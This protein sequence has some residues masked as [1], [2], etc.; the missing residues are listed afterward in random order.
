MRGRM[1]AHAGNRQTNV[2]KANFLLF[3]SF[4]Q[5]ATLARQGKMLPLQ[6][7]LRQCMIELH[8][9]QFDG[10]EIHALMI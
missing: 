5:M 1:T 2:S 4:L 6:G 7:K 10:H 3:L 8:R 9:I